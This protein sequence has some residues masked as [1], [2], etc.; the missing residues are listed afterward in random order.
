MHAFGNNSYYSILFFSE[1]KSSQTPSRVNKE[2]LKD[3]T[4]YAEGLDLLQISVL[5]RK[6]TTTKKEQ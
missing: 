5:I 1:L 4:S 3:M 2:Q 6:K